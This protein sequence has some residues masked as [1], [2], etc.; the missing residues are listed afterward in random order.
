MEPLG[1]LNKGFTV[2][3]TRGLPFNAPCECTSMH[4]GSSRLVLPSLFHNPYH[5]HELYQGVALTR[6]RGGPGHGTLR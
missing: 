4:E 2:R 5:Y 1:N 6:S 3:T